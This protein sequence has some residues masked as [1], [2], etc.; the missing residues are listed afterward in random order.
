MREDLAVLGVQ[1]LQGDGKEQKASTIVL[2]EGHHAKM[3]RDARSRPVQRAFAQNATSSLKDDVNNVSSNLQHGTDSH[4]TQLRNEEADLTMQ[5][6]AES[7]ENTNTARD[8]TVQ[9]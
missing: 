8:A 6:A 9:L 3:L 1:H 7:A 4:L 5:A 2:P